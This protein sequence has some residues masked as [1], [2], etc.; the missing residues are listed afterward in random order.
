MKKQ[1]VQAPRD[2]KQVKNAQSRARELKKMGRDAQYHAYEVGIETN[3]MRKFEL[4]P[5]VNYACMQ[6]G[7]YI[8]IIY[9]TNNKYINIREFSATDNHFF[10]SEM[11]HEFELLL[12]RE[13]L[14]AVIMELDTTFDIGNYYVTFI[15]F[16]HSEFEDL[17]DNPMPT[18]GL[19]CFIHTSKQ[20]SS[21]EYFLN[22]IKEEIPP[23]QSAK[24]VMMCTDD[25]TAI[26]NAFKKV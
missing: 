6:F 21:H 2:I 13:D 16:R 19:A 11:A 3:F 22:M 24:N 10:V 12:N 17:P 20:Q 25:E 26:V 1:A 23:L 9:K 4:F 15:T 5:N 7:K 18:M 14:P 8:Y